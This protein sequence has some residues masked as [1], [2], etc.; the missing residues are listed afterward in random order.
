MESRKTTKKVLFII[1]GVVLVSSCIQ[2][3]MTQDEQNEAPCPSWE[4]KSERG[5]QQSSI[6]EADYDFDVTNETVNIFVQYNGLLKVEY[7]ITFD[8]D[9]G[10]IEYIDLGLPQGLD[11]STAVANIT[12]G[13]MD[14]QIAKSD[15]GPPDRSYI[16]H[17]TTIYLG[18]S[19]EIFPGE[20]GTLHFI[21]NLSN[22]LYKDSQNKS[23]ASFKFAPTWFDNSIGGYFVQDY[24]VTFY[25]PP[26][27][28]DGS[29]LR[30][31]EINDPDWKEPT[32]GLAN[33]TNPLEQRL[34]YR[35]YYSSISH[36][37]HVFGASF[38]V[39]WVADG[40][41]QP[42]P[43][44]TNA[45]WT[46]LVIFG[47][48][49]V[50]ISAVY[51]VSKYQKKR[52]TQ[53]Y[54]PVQKKKNPLGGMVCCGFWVMII[55]VVVFFEH[56]ATILF[57]L[58]IGLVVGAF[59]FIAYFVARWI[60]K[61]RIKYE[62]PK[63][64]IECAGVNKNLTVPESAILKNTPLGRVIFLI[65][66]GMMKKELISIESEKPLLFG[67]EK[68]LFLDNLR[69]MDEK[70]RKIRDYELD[71]Y[72]AIDP[73]TKKMRE[74]KLKDA[75]IKMIKK[76]HKKMVG[77]DLQ[78]TITY[79]ENLMKKAWKQVH[80]SKGEINLDEIEE[81]FEYMLLDDEFED[82]APRVFG[83]RPV[84]VPHWYRSYYWWRR[85]G[86]ITGI[87]GR[88]VGTLG[89]RIG[90]ASFNMGSFANSI[91]T[92]LENVSNNIATNVSNFFNSIV[93]KVSPPPPKSSGGSFSGGGRS[94]GGH[95]CACA[96]ACACA[97]CA[98]ACAGGGR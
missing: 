89:G 87:P 81:E 46:A 68:K 15:I 74:S 35:W 60:D 11:R 77:F 83:H 5:I 51:L 17:G 63:L 21:G 67:R 25:F 66:F 14:Y 75:L 8:V 91:A 34:Y 10:P 1:F 69:K 79:H 39:S 4:P 38:P 22:M 59:A 95:S 92:G 33:F 85:P 78:A 13:G 64:S 42:N 6:H 37:K 56:L 80:D 90:G 49:T 54:P 12:V 93:S 70:G 62:K 88:G 52:K 40:V 96:C 3:S 53:Y 30:W 94:Y 24:Q 97:G 43:A 72:E 31:H 23:K 57:A 82:K 16:D 19:R 71:I 27:E 65:L 48:I 84:L 18:N 28:V 73:K 9:D 98:C 32:Y 36:E 7:Y 61:R 2:L 41:V 44:V 50:A 26:N 86:V 29:Q 20:Q 55:L 58:S 76:V 47:G 45:I